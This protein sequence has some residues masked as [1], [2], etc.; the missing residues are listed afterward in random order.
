M[1]APYNKIFMNIKKKEVLNIR[2]YND[3][4]GTTQST[5]VGG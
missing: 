4:P 2:Y 5:E 3:T 1:F